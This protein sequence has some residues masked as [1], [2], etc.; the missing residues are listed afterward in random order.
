MHKENMVHLP[1]GAYYSALGPPTY[2]KILNPD[3][4]LPKGNAGQK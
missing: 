2:L 4:Y 1:N 3:L